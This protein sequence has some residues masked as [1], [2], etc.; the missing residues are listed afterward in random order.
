MEKKKILKVVLLIVIVLIVIFAIHIIRNI[1]IINEISE[2]QDVL[3]KS[4]NYYYVTENNTGAK[5]EIYYKD[6]ISKT[7]V[8]QNGYTMVTWVNGNTHETVN[9]FPKTMKANISFNAML[10]VSMV[11]LSNSNTFIT[12]LI[13]SISKD[14]ING[15]ECYVVKNST[16]TS[17]I[18]KEDGRMLKRIGGKTVQNGAETEVTVEYKDWKFDKLTDDDMAR[19][20][21]TGYDVT[22]Q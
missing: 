2:K 17:Y 8:E 12:A 10:N 13:S 22:E 20:D 16:E 14:T 19:P 21:L 3:S 11:T 7:V 6:R 15:E 1:M 18:S 5:T 4:N 9:Y